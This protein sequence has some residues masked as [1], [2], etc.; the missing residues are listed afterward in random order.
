M[1]RLKFQTF[2]RSLE[3]PGLKF[4]LK[5]FHLLVNGLQFCCL[6][7]KAELMSLQSREL[8]LMFL[9]LT[10]SL[11][12]LILS[13]LKVRNGTIKVLYKQP[14]KS[15]TTLT[16]GEGI[17]NEKSCHLYKLVQQ[18]NVKKDH[19]RRLLQKLLQLINCC[20]ELLLCWLQGSDGR[21]GF[22]RSLAFLRVKETSSRSLS[23]SPRP[24]S[25]DRACKRKLQVHK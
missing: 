4:N 13:C 1:N 9:F 17:G 19:V 16:K 6:S 2:L 8:L 21:R 12:S 5:E 7:L 11:I 18:T 24:L 25:E 10:F 20:L 15:P 14:Q 23:T 3:L 22:S